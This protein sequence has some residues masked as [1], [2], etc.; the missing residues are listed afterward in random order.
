MI[1]KGQKAPEISLFSNEKKEVRVADFQGKKHVLLLFFPQA[2][3]GVCTNEL[4][5]VNN[6][7]EEYDKKD[8]QVLGISTDSPFTL[9]EYAKVNALKFP[10]L[11]D[12][13]AVIGDAFGIKYPAGGF[14]LG[15]SRV[16]KRS[17]FIIDKEG[18]VRYA[19]VL[20]NAGHLPNFEAIK[21]CI[22]SL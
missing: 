18:L 5:L 15:M 2:F 12:H 7:L 14:A 9:A 20:E 3:T 13:D 22:N 10:L 21:G 11:S 6:E 17:A 19:E 8:V 4:N 1:T 16:S